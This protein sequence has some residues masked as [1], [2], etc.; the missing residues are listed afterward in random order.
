MTEQIN[1]IGLESPYKEYLALRKT[2]ATRVT[3]T[4]AMG[5]ARKKI[6][7][8]LTECTKFDFELFFKEL[9]DARKSVSHCQILK[10]CLNGFY[11]HEV[12]HDKRKDN[13]MELVMEQQFGVKS[14]AHPKALNVEQRDK[15]LSVLKWD[16]T[17]FEQKMALAVLFGFREGFRRF[18]IAKCCWQ[19]IEWERNR[20]RVWG[21]GRTGQDPDYVPLSAEL[22]Q[23]LTTYRANV[24]KAKIDSPWIFFLD[25][26]PS[27]H[28][29]KESVGDWYK[30]IGKLAGFDKS[31]VFSSHVGRHIF[32]TTLNEGGLAPID[33]IKMS[34]H[35]TTGL[36]EER[37]V[38][39]REERTQEQ[40]KSVI[41]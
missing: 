19:D 38:K 15:V 36:Y 39:I 31:V 40:F 23:R 16:G 32:C 3:Y 6:G 27:R 9:G 29:K 37:Y 33:A 34:R 28:L 35:K 12:S 4:A 10:S 25:T 17:L 14:G 30:K 8:E 24:Q 7:K 11:K 13:P 2:E 5:Y 1:H 22:R 18:E 21:K 26:D 20:I 41:P